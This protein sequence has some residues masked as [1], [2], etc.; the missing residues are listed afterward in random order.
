MRKLGLNEVI[1]LVHSPTVQRQAKR[2]SDA[3]QPVSN[4]HWL[5]T[6]HTA[7][8][9]ATTARTQKAK[10]SKGGGL[11]KRAAIGTTYAA[12]WSL[13]ED[14]EAPGEGIGPTPRPALAWGRSSAIDSGAEQRLSSLLEWEFGVP[15]GLQEP[16]G[17]PELS[18]P[19]S[20]RCL[21]SPQVSRE[22]LT[23]PRWRSSCCILAPSGG[24][25]RNSLWVSA[26]CGKLASWRKSPG[27]KLEW[28][29]GRR[30]GAVTYSKS[31]IMF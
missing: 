29:V 3:N 27:S 12:L 19:T 8:F 15:A 17:S 10:S 24:Q 21:E 31:L 11:A 5:T 2:D 18:L 22:L 23:P 13:A 16:G 30:R 14:L 25:C 20:P 26:H 9:P 4:A 7:S 6:E 28:G 1:S